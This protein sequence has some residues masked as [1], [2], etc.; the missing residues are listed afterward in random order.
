[1]E[2]GVVLQFGPGQDGADAIKPGQTASVQ[3]TVGSVDNVLF[4][5]SSSI[6]TAGGQSTVTVMKNGVATPTPV[7]IGMVGDSTTEI[8][9]GLNEGD[10]VLLSPRSGSS[11][12][13]GGSR[14][15]F[16]GSGGLGGGFGGGT[17]GF[18]GGTTGGRGGNG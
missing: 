4:V 18:G 17:G 13:T 9:S 3:V 16:G 5:P 8:T 1:V 14:G 6:V 7:Q 15:G 12:T 10:Q 2:Y 11:S